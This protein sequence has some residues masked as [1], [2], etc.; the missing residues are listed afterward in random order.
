M[1]NRV[2]G[3]KF[4]F[5]LLF[6]VFWIEG[7]SERKNSEVLVSNTEKGVIAEN[8]MV[9]SARGE[10]SKIGVEILKKGGNAFDA[11]I[12]TDLAL[13]VCYPQAGNIGGGGFMVYRK[14][15]GETGSIDY[16]EKAPVEASRDMYLDEDG[17]PIPDKSRFGGLSVGV[18]GTIAG[19]F[20]IHK[21]LGSLPFEDLINPSIEL[22][23]RGVVVTEMQAGNFNGV[24]EKI[25]KVN[26]EISFI[27]RVW[28]PGDTMKLPALARTLERIRDNGRDEFYKGETGEL[29][30]QHLQSLG[31]IIT[32]EDLASYRAI[33][34][35]PIESQYHT[36]KII[37]MGPPSSGGICL[38]Q[39]LKSVESFD[40][41]KM[42]HNGVPY[43]QLL[44]ESERRV[45]ADR[46]YFL[47]DPDFIEIPVETLL[48]SEYN[49]KRMQSFSFDSATASSEISHGNIEVVESDQTTHYSIV[50]A[51]GNAVAVTTT[52]NSG[53]GSKVF[54]K[55]AG[56]F[57][58]NEM[59]DFSSKVGYP[60]KY[61]LVGAEANA[62]APEKR[63]LS[64]MTPTIIEEEGKLK[65]VVGSPGG[66]TIITSVFQNIL[67][68]LEYDM[69]MQESV[70]SIRFHHQWL[71]DKIRFEETFDTIHFQ[72]LRQKGYHPTII[73]SLGRVDA[74]LV[75]ED[76]RLEA[77]ADPR[78]DDTAVG[79]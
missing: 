17:V 16:R 26:G 57:L 11:M 47:G 53:Y 46:A 32:M 77:G 35:D 43:I 58:N 60:N 69:G 39:L 4:L 27:H 59:D 24:K 34:R 22:A 30:V 38:S 64:S 50:D 45:Y 79:Y 25:E 36:Y 20:E 41:K 40:F 56:F 21:K 31:G 67:N 1:R 73:S 48:S 78:G 14:S 75:M 18:P 54:V 29:M 55:S 76:G 19:L 33:W 66:S 51:Q 61:G 23:K 37:S 8:G 6:L 72:A 9:V 5:A 2:K 70:S 49:R 7:C 62:I 74:I 65:M 28:K 52:L 10:A 12:A 3:F 63:M 44:T 68:V 71:P 42:K 13:A 15:D